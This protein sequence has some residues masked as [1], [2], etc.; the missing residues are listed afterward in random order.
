MIILAAGSAYGIFFAAESPD[1]NAVNMQE[2]VEQPTGEYRDRQ[3]E[4]EESTEW[5]T[6][7]IESNAGSY[8]D[9][10]KID[11]GGGLT[12]LYAHCASICATV[13]QQADVGQGIA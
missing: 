12:T 7:E 2:A 8:G 11:H 13:G 1:E 3:E 4:I 9:H 5:T 10:V 6:K